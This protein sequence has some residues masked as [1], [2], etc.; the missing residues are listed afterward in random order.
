MRGSVFADAEGIVCP[1]ELDGQF[2]KRGHADGGLHVVGE[3]EEC[4]HRRDD[5][6]VERHADADAGHREFRNAGLEEAA[7]EVG[8][9]DFRSVFQEAVRL[10]GVAEVGRG[11]NHIG[12]IFREQREAGGRAVARGLVGFLLDGVPRNFGQAVVHPVVEAGCLFGVGIGPGPLFGVAFLSPGAEFRLALFVHLAH[13]GPHD[14]GIFGVA[15]EVFN[16]I[17]VSV[18]AEGCAV[19]LAVALVACAVGFACALAHHAV[20]DDE[21]GAVLLF[22]GGFEGGADLFG[23]VAVDFKHVPVPCAVFHARVFGDNGRC[24]GGKLNFIGVEEHDEVVQSEVSRDASCALR[25]FLLHAAVGDVGIDAFAL[26]AGVARAGVKGFGC[27]GRTHGVG[28]PLSQRAAGI[29]DAAL[30]AYFRVSRCARAPLAE[31]FQVVYGVVPDKCELRVKHRR[32]V[33]G[34]QEET[35]ATSPCGTIRVEVKEL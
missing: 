17:H 14:E 22:V 6:A 20:S 1:N 4:S 16:R 30:G 23:V 32:H 15:A 9:R 3:D 33:S 24:F 27:D 28:V 11:D 7:A 13:F 12:H 2:H 31:V 19:R 29:L 25:D 26:K 35:V 10:V 18:A 8:A 21:G 34:I 5:A